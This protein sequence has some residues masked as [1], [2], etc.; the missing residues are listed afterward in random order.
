MW[1]VTFD[2]L[3][4]FCIAQLL[5][6]FDKQT[7]ILDV[8]DIAVLITVVCLLKLGLVNEL[9]LKVGEI[10]FNLLLIFVVLVVIRWYRVLAWAGFILDTLIHVHFNVYFELLVL[11]KL[12]WLFILLIL[13]N[14]LKW[15]L[16]VLLVLF[17]LQILI[18]STRGTLLVT[19]IF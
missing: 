19:L 15:I 3:L 13:S 6:T 9:K 2:G 18:I 7:Y 11:W 5:L 16:I 17:L 1:E 14:L 4:V 12:L 8:Q 10:L